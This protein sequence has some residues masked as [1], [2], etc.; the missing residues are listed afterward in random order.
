MIKNL[1]I[2]IALL[3]VVAV[4]GAALWEKFQPIERS[5]EYYAVIS[6]PIYSE[7]SSIKFISIMSQKAE[8]IRRVDW[9][10]SILCD[11][12]N[13]FKEVD[14][15]P[16]GMDNR[17]ASTTAESLVEIVKSKPTDS[18]LY[19]KWRTEVIREVE[20]L[21]KSSW[22]YQ[23]QEM[24]W[25]TKNTLCYGKHKITIKTPYFGFDRVIELNSSAFWLIGS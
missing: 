5:M 18:A 11:A 2:S 9:R 8:I 21:G 1:M 16:S 15:Y 23:I 10:D 6:Y 4:C 25:P 17:K 13:G 14:V 24:E 20:R 3:V 12:G 22:K 19:N 7:N